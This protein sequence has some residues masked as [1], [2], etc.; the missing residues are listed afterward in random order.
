M[1]A[2]AAEVPMLTFSFFT[3]HSTL[4]SRYNLFN[5]EESIYGKAWKNYYF[6]KHRS[7]YTKG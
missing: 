4:A 1:L 2:K 5:K 6:L 3:K 7:Y